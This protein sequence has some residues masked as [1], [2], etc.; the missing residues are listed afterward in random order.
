[1]CLVVFQ[2][3]VRRTMSDLGLREREREPDLF[4]ASSSG[5]GSRGARNVFSLILNPPTQ[6][7]SW[8]WKETHGPNHGW[9]NQ[10]V[11]DD[12]RNEVFDVLEFLKRG[13]YNTGHVQ[14]NQIRTSWVL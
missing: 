11:D 8:C 12:G 2:C 5:S 7:Q 1:M 14:K 4:G 3:F 9:V 6:N 13:S 10:V